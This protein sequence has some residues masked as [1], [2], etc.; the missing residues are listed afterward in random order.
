M[1][2]MYPT[3]GAVDLIAGSIYVWQIQKRI[4]TTAGLEVINS[5]IYAYL[6]KETTV[7]PVIQAL[8]EILPEEVLESYLT[9]CGPLTGFS[10]S[11]TLKLDGE[12]VDVTSLN[13]LVEQFRQ[14]DRTLITTEVR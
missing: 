11:G 3:T 7:D 9:P 10:P 14:G 8:G 13:E 6:I 2:Y 4:S 12:E 1:S 5:P